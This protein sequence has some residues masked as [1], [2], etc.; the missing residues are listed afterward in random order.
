MFFNNSSG[1]LCTRWNAFPSVASSSS[2]ALSYSSFFILRKYLRFLRN[3]SWIFC[4]YHQDGFCD[5]FFFDSVQ[6][7][8]GQEGY[9]FRCVW[10]LQISEALFYLCY[11]VLDFF[12]WHVEVEEHVSKVQ[13]AYIRGCRKTNS[14]PMTPNS[15]SHKQMLNKC[16]QTSTKM[17]FS[18]RQPGSVTRT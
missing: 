18:E 7:G 9:I 11:Y 6:L 10:F 3:F 1:F 17:K 8:C 5:N 12:L 2:A 4:R 16:L 15:S 14:N 13:L